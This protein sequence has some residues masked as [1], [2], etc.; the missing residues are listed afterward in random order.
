MKKLF[1][2]TSAEHNFVMVLCMQHNLENK[3][4]YLQNKEAFQNRCTVHYIKA[5]LFTQSLLYLFYNKEHCRSSNF[6]SS[7]FA[8]TYCLQRTFPQ[9]FS[10][11]K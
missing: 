6:F 11:P 5:L 9:Y 8:V 2:V 10:M 1:S 3:H 4:L 7:G